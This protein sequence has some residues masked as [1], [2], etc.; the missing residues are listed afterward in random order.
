MFKTR[1]LFV[2]GAGAS[3]EV[4]FP[5]GNQ[6][7]QTI[8]KKLNILYDDF[9]SRIIAGDSDLFLQVTHA[10]QLEIREYQQA[11]WRIRD[12]IHLERV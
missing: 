2:V 1:T 7:A 12:G 11:A 9:G 10:C 4:N 3:A 5:V 6:L 8:G